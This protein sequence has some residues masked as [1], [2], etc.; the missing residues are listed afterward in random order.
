[1]GTANL[2]LRLRKFDLV[3]QIDHS[4]TCEV[5]ARCGTARRAEKPDARQHYLPRGGARSL[6]V[7]VTYRVEEVA[8]MLRLSKGRVYELIRRGV[9]PAIH[10]GKQ[11]RVP[12]A[13]FHAWLEGRRRS[14]DD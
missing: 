14:G 1:M 7:P 8:E 10:L 3:T 12:S 11:V 4:V 5:G 13:A 2:S 9:I 6:A